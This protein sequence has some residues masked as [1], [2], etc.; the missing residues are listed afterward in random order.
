MKAKLVIEP[1]VPTESEE[2][3]YKPGSKWNYLVWCNKAYVNYF[4]RVYGK[5]PLRI[6]PV[7]LNIVDKTGNIVASDIRV[8]LSEDTIGNILDRGGECKVKIKENSVYLFD[9]KC[10]PRHAI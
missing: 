4:L 1:F 2:F 10:E 9:K 3:Y 7:R 5:I 8:D 6:N